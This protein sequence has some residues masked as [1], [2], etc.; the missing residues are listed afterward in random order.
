MPRADIEQGDVLERFVARISERLSLEKGRCF[1]VAMPELRASPPGGEYFVTVAPGTGSFDVEL[2]IGGGE[3]QCTEE[4][5]VLVTVYSRIKLDQSGHDDRLLVDAGRGL[6]KLKRLVL[7]ALVGNDLETDGGDTF[8]RQ[9][10]YVISCGQPEYDKEKQ[11]GWLS[12]VFGV[13]WDW[14]LSDE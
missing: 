7:K 12:M 11:I 13:S 8:L 6:Y 10:L 1:I 14:D 2:Q 4:W 3:F 9:L 5:Q